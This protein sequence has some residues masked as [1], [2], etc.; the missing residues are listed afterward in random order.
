MMQIF[1]P[2]SQWKGFGTS[3]A[4]HGPT[5]RRWGRKKCNIIFFDGAGSQGAKRVDLALTRK[6]WSTMTQHSS[7]LAAEHEPETGLGTHVNMRA[8]VKTYNNQSQ[9]P[10]DMGILHHFR[11]AA[12]I[13]RSFTLL[14]DISF[15][16]SPFLSPRGGEKAHNY[17]NARRGFASC[18][19]TVFFIIIP[20]FSRLV[21]SA[22]DPPPKR[23]RLRLGKIRLMPGAME[24]PGN[25]VRT[26]FGQGWSHCIC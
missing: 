26:R 21:T 25:A 6:N 16:Y 17:R 24:S 22:I 18:T 15:T 14:H 5:T 13:S 8:L 23:D 11:R 2:P 10:L 20:L 4:N 3:P 1:C 12:R 7:G 9:F 19:S